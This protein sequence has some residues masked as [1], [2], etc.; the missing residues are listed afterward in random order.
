[1]LP[2]VWL[3]SVTF[4]FLSLLLAWA[5]LSRLG[6]VAIEPRG[7]P[8]LYLPALNSQMHIPAML[9]FTTGTLQ[10]EIP[11]PMPVQLLIHVTLEHGRSLGYLSAN[12]SKKVAGK[13]VV[14]YIVKAA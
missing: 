1:M 12:L 13:Q 7:C 9:A 2:Q 5:L 11:W 6:Q 4:V 8:H 3:T 10:K 14:S